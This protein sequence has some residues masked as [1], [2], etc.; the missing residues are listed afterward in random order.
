M[1]YVEKHRLYD[2]ALVLWCGTNKY[3]VRDSSSSLTVIS[4]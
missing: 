2:H 3:E 1:S 4:F